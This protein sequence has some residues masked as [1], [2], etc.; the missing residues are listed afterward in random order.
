MTVDKNVHV[1]KKEKKVKTQNYKNKKVSNC[2]I[3]RVYDRLCWLE[4]LEKTMRA[5]PH[6]VAINV[7]TN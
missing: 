5:L 3:G 1:K 2:D 4:I 7:N 6:S